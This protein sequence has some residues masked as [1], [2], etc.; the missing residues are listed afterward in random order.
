[1]CSRVFVV[2]QILH[3]SNSNLNFVQFGFQNIE[4]NYTLD[5]LNYTCT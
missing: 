4:I 2:S 1:M 3:N 5:N